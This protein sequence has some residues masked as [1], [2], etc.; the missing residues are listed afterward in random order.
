MA[1]LFS[2][3]DPRAEAIMIGLLR[4]MTPEQRLERSF[5]LRA[6]VVALA[7]ARILHDHPDA[8]DRD[9]RMRIFSLWHDAATMRRVWNWDPDVEGY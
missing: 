4:R 7:R 2:D 6:T 8:P 5:E 9:V 1:A 3:T